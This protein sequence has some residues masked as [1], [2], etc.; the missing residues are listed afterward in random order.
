MEKPLGVSIMAV[1]I[2]LGGMVMIIAGIGAMAIA[3]MLQVF[4]QSQDAPVLGGIAVASGA[5]TLA[6]GIASIVVAYGLLKGRRWAWTAAVALSIASIVVAAI[7]IAGGSY[8]SA[9]SVIINGMTLYYLFKP[10]VRAYFGRVVA[11]R[12]GDAAAA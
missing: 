5:I 11:T 3:P 8:G 1:L 10:H 6:L 9:I 12:A 7:S 4:S 2:G